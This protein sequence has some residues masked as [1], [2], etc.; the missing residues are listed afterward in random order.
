MPLGFPA[1]RHATDLCKSLDLARGPSIERRR[2]VNGGC[3]FARGREKR[4]ESL[5]I[6]GEKRAR[7]GKQAATDLNGPGSGKARVEE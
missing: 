7:R 1:T 5:G 6:R 2:E 3:D 4:D